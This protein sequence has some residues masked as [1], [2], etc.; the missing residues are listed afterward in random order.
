M[1]APRRAL[2]RPELNAPTT[3]D[4]IPP[5]TAAIRIECTWTKLQVRCRPFAVPDL[6]ALTC[7]LCGRAVSLENCK[8]DEYGEAVHEECYVARI[9][10][11]RAS[12]QWVADNTP[13]RGEGATA[14]H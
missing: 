11:E 3:A 14:G 7:W 13:T 2:P 5:M 6:H 10:L 1:E 12:A 9:A 4:S 8:T